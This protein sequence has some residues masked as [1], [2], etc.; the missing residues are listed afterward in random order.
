M[1]SET[2]QAFDLIVLGAGPAGASAARCAARAGLRVALIDKARF[3]RDKLCGG[4]LT[5]RAIGQFAQIF[6]RPL[7]GVPLEKR[8]EITFHA[9]GEDLGTSV[10]APPLHLAMRREFDAHLVDMAIEAGAV[11][12][13]GQDVRR[14]G[15]CVWSGE[16][17]L[18]APLLIAADGVNSQTAKELF[19]QAFDRDKIGFALEVEQPGGDPARPLRIDFGAADWGYGW[20]FPKTC[21]TTVGVGG[22][23]ARNPDMK[24]HM[25][26]YMADLGIDKSLKV[27]GQFLPFGELRPVPGQGRV[28]LAGDAAG[29]VDPLTGEGIAYAMQSGA[30]AARAVL[31]ALKASR[32]DEALRAYRRSLR[33]IH[34][35]IR[36]AARLRHLMFNPRLRPFF[37][38][39]FSGSQRMRADYL[40]LLAGEM[41]YGPLMRRLM[42]R[43]PGKMLRALG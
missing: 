41:E 29:L 22:I 12:F 10:D 39:Q 17:H 14:D 35:N 43:L 20:Q 15:T 2:G 21:G 8:S 26:R 31:E 5:G 19:G 24:A 34:A 1:S 33:P 38:R 9:F 18:Q 7:P 42:F 3:P 13:T 32:P 36:H 16:T 30:L 27:K 11:D 40:H 28:L 37:L 4:G 25:A 6:A 23:M